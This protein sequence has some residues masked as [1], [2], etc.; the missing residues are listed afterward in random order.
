MVQRVFV[1]L[2]TAAHAPTKVQPAEPVQTLFLAAVHALTEAAVQTVLQ[3]DL[4]RQVQVQATL[5]VEAAMDL[6]TAAVAAMVHTA[7]AA[8]A[9]VH[10]TAE[11]AVVHT[12]VAATVAE[13]VVTVNQSERIFTN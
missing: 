2:A 4:N 3:T 6:L 7:E 9:V 10:R 11:A 12:A 8:A 1:A 5:I 13:A